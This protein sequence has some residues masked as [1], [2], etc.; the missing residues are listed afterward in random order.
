MGVKIGRSFDELDGRIKQFNN[1]LKQTQGELR[2]VDKELALDPN[3]IDLASKK[4]QLLQQNL[5]TAAAKVTTL[6]QKQDALRQSYE[7]GEIT[8]DEYNRRLAATRT[9]LQNAELQVRQMTVA[10]KEQNKAVKDANYDKLTQG[11]DKAESIAKKARAA[12][13]AL[14]G[15][16]VAMF[17]AAVKTGDELADNANHYGTTV[18]DLQI[19]SNRLGMLA[20]DQDAYTKALEKTGAFQASITGGRGA[21]YLTFLQQLGITQDD[22]N[23][24]TSGEVFEM[25]YEAMRNLT[26]E[27]QRTLIAQGLFGD[28]GL[29]I[30]AIARTEQEQIDA[31]D[32]TM[33]DG[34]L[35]TTEQAVAADEAANKM[36]AIKQQAQAANM[37][38]MV[39]LMPTFEAL[40]EILRET[41]IPVLNSL[42]EWFSGM[43]QD[44]QKA[45]LA[46][47]AILIILPT[48]I[49]MIKGVVTTIQM[50]NMAKDLHALA[51]Y[52]Q[53]GAMTAL[54][55]ASAPWLP[56][57]LAIAAA[58]MLLISIINLFIGKSNE[59]T[60]ASEDL[61][62]RMDEL[63]KKSASF[64][65][66]AEYNAVTTYQAGSYKKSDI[67]VNVTA[68]GETKLSKENAEAVADSI[69][70]S[71]ITKI[72]NEG[73]GNIVRR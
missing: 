38:L 57:I 9:V 71:I 29:E 25:V 12:V 16:L 32:A 46:T 11:L 19:W 21:K 59:A 49:G 40:T 56:I 4:T 1:S 68:T 58:L 7:S 39:S 69:E 65:T 70:D 36:L 51:T 28:V 52:G 42:S 24:K 17:T 63:E 72:V 67:N 47:L 27:T 54:T 33:R 44:E 3:N 43:T 45:L 55:T 34:R 2:L 73:M 10:V 5:Q 48:L 31:L 23:N 64:N 14:T 20:K 30:A 50:L 41:V 6:K 15:A 13:L 60:D 53:A 66:E 8:E 37:E 61:L 35:I 18:E 22:I 62:K 26:D